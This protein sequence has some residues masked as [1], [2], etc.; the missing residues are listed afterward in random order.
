MLF[1]ESYD[2]DSDLKKIRHF[3][4]WDEFVEFIIATVVNSNV[5]QLDVLSKE[6]GFKTVDEKDF[7]K[8][9]HSELGFASF[10]RIIN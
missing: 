2:A 9:K 10:S 5:E 3:S 7:F 4:G 6:M 8:E 1:K